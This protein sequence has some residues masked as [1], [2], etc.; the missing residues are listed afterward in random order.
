M[1][2]KQVTIRRYYVPGPQ[3]WH[4]SSCPSKFHKGYTRL[5]EP[6]N[7]DQIERQN[8]NL[9]IL[10]DTG[11]VPIL[12]HWQLILNTPEYFYCI[13]PGA[14]LMSPVPESGPIPLG[15]LIRL[16]ERRR[17]MDRCPHCW[18]WICILGAA[19]DLSTTDHTWWGI[20]L[21]C[22][23]SVDNNGP[24]RIFCFTR[25]LYEPARGL[26]RVYNNVPLLP[27]LYASRVEPVKFIDLLKIFQDQ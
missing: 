24:E 18:E 10:F 27:S 22:K 20:C 23:G 9:Q 15:V 12:K 21:T 2:D 16:W 26:L 11:L 25:D 7:Q 5:S 13:I 17:W 4:L 19:G 8:T 3:R 6:I 14:Y 1:T